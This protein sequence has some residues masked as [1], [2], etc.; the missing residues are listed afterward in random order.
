MKKVILAAAACA[1]LAPSVSRAQLV[2]GGQAGVTFPFGDLQGSKLDGQVARVFPLELRA[3]WRVK[4]AL[5]VGL[6]GGYGIASEGDARAASCRAT[7]ADC[8]AHLWRVAARVDYGF[9]G[10]NWLPY[11]AGTL[12]WQWL[13]ERWELASGNWDQSRWGGWL[14]GAEGGIDRPLSP[15]LRAGAFV[16]AGLG[17][18]LTVSEEGETAGYAHS[19][20]GTLPSPSVN[21]WLGL[22]LRVTWAM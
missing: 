9:D 14:L 1:L 7:T 16:A 12:G 20:A 4:P 5:T 19:D 10:V 13:T 3:G 11:V 2:L 6:Q 17:Q 8:T 22:G 18:F 21:A 15:K